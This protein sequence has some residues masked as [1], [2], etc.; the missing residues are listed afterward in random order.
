MS[1]NNIENAKTLNAGGL[2]WKVVLP[3]AIGLAVVA[4]LFSGEYN[5]EVWK[6]FRLDWRTITAF[7]LSWVTIFGRDFGFA[8]RF[9][10]LTDN[11]LSWKQSA[12][13]TMLCEFTSCVTPTTAGGSTFA[14]LYL[15]REGIKVGRATTLMLTTLFLDELFFVVC[16][17]VVFCLIPYSELFGFDHTTFSSGLRTVFWCVYGVLASWTVVLYVGIF[18]KP[19]GIHKLLN[20]VFRLPILRRWSN[21]IDDMGTQIELAG[22][23][24]RIRDLMWWAKAFSATCVS[25]ISRFLLVNVLFFGLAPNVDQVIVLVR[26]FVVWVILTVSPTPGGAGISEWLFT[27]YYGD[28]LSNHSVILVIALFWRIFSYYVYLIVGVCILPWWVRNKFNL[29]K[30]GKRRQ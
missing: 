4:W 18:I 22:K 12:R 19:K 1:E 24:L 23:E 9:R 17:P 2:I 6:S 10:S 29:S 25:W 14:L 7:V 5:P 28:M 8:W 21:Y 15:N 13:V 20:W 16:L 11:Q 27:T 3:V 26:Q 30:H